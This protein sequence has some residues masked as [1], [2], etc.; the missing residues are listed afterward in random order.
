MGLKNLQGNLLCAIDTETTGLD[1]RRHDIIQIAILPLNDQIQPDKRFMPFNIHIKP[2]RPENIEAK[3]MQVNKIN[4]AHLMLHG[5]DSFQAADLLDEW[6]EKL[7]LPLGRKIVPLGQNYAFDREFMREWLGHL[8]YDHLFHYHY[9]DT[10]IAAQ[11]INDRAEIHGNYPP[12]SK[13]SLGR[14]AGVLEIEYQNAHDALA[15]C[16]IV[17]E[18]YRRMMRM[19]LGV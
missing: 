5:M 4:L 16:V 6:F 1:P 19:Y 13:G 10:M 18:C 9:K 17:S 7:R 11:Y 8:N 15:D 2:S 12:F 3:A 14:I